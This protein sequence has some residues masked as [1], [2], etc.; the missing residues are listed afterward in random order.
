[1]AGFVVPER[2]RGTPL[3]ILS[4]FLFAVMAL[5][6]RMLAGR[7]S[8]GQVVVGRF[9]VGLLFLAGYY[10][11]ARRL[12]RFS[13]FGTWVGR[14]VFGGASVYLYFVSID[15]LAVGPSVLLN[16]CWPIY[17]A[18]LGIFFLR[19]RVSAQV[20]T[21]LAVTTVGAALVIWSTVRDAGAL[22]LGVGAWAGIGSAV[23]SGAAVVCVRVLRQGTDSATVFLSFCL[24]GLLCGLP[25]AFADWRPLTW[26][27]ALP[28]LG[29]GVCSV[30]GQMLL[31]YA[32]GYVTVA[33]SG[34]A[35]QLTPAFSWVLGALLLGEAVS[36]LAVS[37]ALVCVAG[38]LWGTGV[39]ER[40][41]APVGKPAA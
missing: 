28:L 2:Y 27:V 29:V 25:F 3:L 39:V 26:D 40:L 35:T 5:F 22:T 8:V 11:S 16:T 30:G 34:L 21:G 14:G 37:G 38:V 9:V 12:P 20:L 32:L 10:T 6:V 15:R 23:L 36:P 7:L 24:F 4:S 33:G 17:A 31:T 13:H 1:M 41:R 18:V 19:E